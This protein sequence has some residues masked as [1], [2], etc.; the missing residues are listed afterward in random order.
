MRRRRA[1]AFK[2][3]YPVQAYQGQQQTQQSYGQQPQQSYGGGSYGQ[4]QSYGNQQ[5][6]NNTHS[7]EMG[8]AQQGNGGDN[9]QAPPGCES[10]RTMWIED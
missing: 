10:D 5:Q 7:Y 9:Y 2:A 8:Q 3:A 4:Q 1:R 6:Y